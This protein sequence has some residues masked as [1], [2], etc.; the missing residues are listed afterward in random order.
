ME[1]F[2][3]DTPYA[4]MFGPDIC[5]HTTKRVHV[6]LPYDNDNHLIDHTIPC[7]TDV[8]THVYTL[9]IRP[10]NTYEVLIFVP[11]P[12]SVSKCCICHAST[13]CYDDRIFVPN[14]ATSNTHC[15]VSPVP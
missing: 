8:F 6:I 3:G 1:S 12:R 9:A 4:I 5:G 15:C 2:S 14:M 11:I 13:C 7:E 10:D